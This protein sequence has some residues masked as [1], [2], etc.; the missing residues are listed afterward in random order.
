MHK[1]YDWISDHHSL[2]ALQQFPLRFFMLFL[3]YSH[4]A[5]LIL[6]LKLNKSSD[7]IPY[8]KLPYRYDWPKEDSQRI[9]ESWDF[10]W[11]LFD[12]E[13]QEDSICRNFDQLKCEDNIVWYESHLIVG[14]VPLMKHMAYDSEVD[15]RDVEGQRK[16]LT[17]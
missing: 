7:Q 12:I 17:L 16:H 2:V 1:E 11:V 5:Q 14:V 3:E 9:E 6:G 4:L 10:F 8:E 13:N 15:K